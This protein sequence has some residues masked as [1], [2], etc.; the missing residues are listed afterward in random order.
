MAADEV[1]AGVAAEE[2]AVERNLLRVAARGRAIGLMN[3][4]FIV[5]VRLANDIVVYFAAVLS[6]RF[7]RAVVSGGRAALKK[8]SAVSVPRLDNIWRE[9]LAHTIFDTTDFRRRPRHP[10]RPP[11][12]TLH[13]SYLHIAI[14]A[15]TANTAA[16][17]AKTPEEIAQENNLLPKLIKNL[18]RHLIFPLLQFVAEQQD[19]DNIDMTKAKYEL[20]KST[21]MTDYIASLYT[22]IHDVKEAPKEFASKRQ[23]VLERLELF[24][25]ETAKITELLGREDVITNL[26]ADKIANLE[27]LK[28]DHDVCA[29][30]LPLG[31]E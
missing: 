27:Y 14:M 16:A 10:R 18:D 24:E 1:A 23:E 5:D 3:D 8:F 4:M 26:R 28:K 7:L 30:G 21:N 25:Q 29:Q 15:D 31:M 13:T 19:E 6:S 22:E 2:V 20:L 12:H 9:V 11:P 17:Q